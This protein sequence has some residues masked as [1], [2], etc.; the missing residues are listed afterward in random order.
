MIT[1]FHIP[2]SLEEARKLMNDGYIVIAGGTQINNGARLAA[3]P[4][5]VAGDQRLVSLQ[6]LGLTGIRRGDDG[7]ALVIGAMTSLQ[8]MADH[9]EVPAALKDAA[10]FIP[11]RNVR[12]QATLGGNIAARRSDS[13]VI[14][15]LIALEARLAA[16]APDGGRKE[17]PVEDYLE[18]PADCLITEIVIPVPEVPCVAVKESRSQLALPVVSAAVA[19]HP[20]GVTGG[21]RAVL[22]A[23]CVAKQSVRLPEVEA[24][25]SGPEPPA[26]ADIEAAVAA[27]V[28][29]RSDTLGSAEYKRH[30]NAVRIADAVLAV[31]ESAGASDG[32]R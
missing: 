24:M 1:S 10:G 28:A 12:N 25:L 17:I 30:V 16:I 27:S 23:G 4:A 29:P 31:F 5:W 15:A 7:R 11:T 21:F 14:P 19:L 8:D 9:Q 6:A 26:R 32:K 22:A 20:A 3:D 13:Y 18:D 2:A